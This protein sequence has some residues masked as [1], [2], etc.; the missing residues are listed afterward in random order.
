MTLTKIGIDVDGVLVNFVNAFR[1]EAETLLGRPFPDEPTD[2]AFKNWNLTKEEFAS[3][4][5]HIEKTENW[6]LFYGSDP[7][8]CVPQVLTQLYADHELYFVTTRIKT[9]GDTTKRQTE[10]SLV[11]MGVELPTV[12]VTTMKGPV[13]SV[14]ELDAFID[15]RPENLEDIQKNSPSTRLF[16][17]TQPWNAAYAAP[18]SWTRVNNLEDFAKKL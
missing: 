13:A 14:L 7:Y 16:L 5:R 8:P 17:L 9:L 15:D 6:Y 11:E 2:W 3:L 18:K 1:R 4:W 10:L 12:V